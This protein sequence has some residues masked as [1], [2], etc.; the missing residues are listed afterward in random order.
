[1]SSILKHGRITFLQINRRFCSFKYYVLISICC[2][3]GAENPNLELPKPPNTCPGCAATSFLQL[4]FVV[5][6]RTTFLLDY[7]CAIFE[8]FLLLTKSLL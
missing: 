2:I 6:E 8:I 5:G 7:Y 1:M 4:N 3:F